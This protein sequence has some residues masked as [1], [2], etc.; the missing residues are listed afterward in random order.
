MHA[1]Q[2]PRHRYP[3]GRTLTTSARCAGMALALFLA[4]TACANL[5]QASPNAHGT[6]ATV[7][8]TDSAFA[9]M[10]RVRVT[11]GEDWL[12]VSG[13]IK[14]Q[15]KGLAPIPGQLRI[16]LLDGDGTLIAEGQTG[17]QRFGRK[18]RVFHFSRRF[19][20]TPDQV[21]TIRVVPHV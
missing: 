8:T 14:K 12:Q 7:I 1:D 4:T 21:E 20:V 10:T 5:G 18:T 17:Y 15:L 9:Q 6:H 16:Q 11:A 3:R 19:E 2:Q 13:R